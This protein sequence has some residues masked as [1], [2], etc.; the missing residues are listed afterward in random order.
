MPAAGPT[1]D[2]ATETARDNPLA[3]PP[4]T[5]A[6]ARERYEQNCYFVTTGTTDLKRI[7]N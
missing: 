5:G 6:S 2:P 7:C 1:A 4:A 3:T